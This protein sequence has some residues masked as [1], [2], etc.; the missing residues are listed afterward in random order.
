ME[1]PGFFQEQA[2][3]PTRCKQPHSLRQQCD[4]AWQHAPG[5]KDQQRHGRHQAEVHQWGKEEG[6]ELGCNDHGGQGHS[7]AAVADQMETCWASQTGFAVGLD[8]K[9]IHINS[10]ALRETITKP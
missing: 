8:P 10:E 9:Y 2:A 5:Q 7:G 4:T 6:G 3:D 1:V